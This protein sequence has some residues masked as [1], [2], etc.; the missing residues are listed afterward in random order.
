VPES[1]RQRVGKGLYTDG[2]HPLGQMC[3]RIRGHFESGAASRD[4][5]KRFQVFD[6]LPPVV[7]AEQNFDD[8]L[9]PL[10]HVSRKPTD[11]FYVD[12]SRLLRC[13]MT[14]HQTELLRAG[15]DAFLMVGDVFR[16]DEIDAT[17]YP[18][19][20]QVDGVRVFDAEHLRSLAGTSP[21]SQR[22]YV[23]ADLKFALEGMVR[24]LFGAATQSKWVDAYFPFTDP[25]T[26]MEILFEDKWLEVLGCGKIRQ[27]ILANCALPA[28]THGW[29]FGMGLERLAMVMYDIPDIR[30]FWSEDARFLDQF[31]SGRP[32]KFKP[33]SKFPPCYK[34]VTFWI[35]D[36]FHENDF[37]VVIREIAGDMVESVRLL[38]EFT[39]PKT[40]RTSRCYRI[41]YRNMDRNLTNAE[42]DAWQADVR[43]ALVSQLGAALR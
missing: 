19:F 43:A 30:L 12:D 32:V 26:E 38:D 2:R 13:H 3:S 20:H 11:T 34:D 37:F 23:M 14:A 5:Q 16:R 17:H 35:P 28:D 40:G 21:E 7:T 22:D 15:H 6:Q 31:A 29:A 9:T 27:Q 42:V 18:I 10:D 39:H 41:N 1:V 36:G 4:G 24:A 8:L 33:Y 25:S